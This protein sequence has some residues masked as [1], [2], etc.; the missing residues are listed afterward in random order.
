[1]NFHTVR[2]NIYVIFLW[3]F[4]WPDQS[5]L[6]L[7]SVQHWY[8]ASLSRPLMDGLWEYLIRSPASTRIVLFPQTNP[9]ARPA[10]NNEKNTSLTHLLSTMSKLNRFYISF[11][12]QFCHIIFKISAYKEKYIFNTKKILNCLQIRLQRFQPR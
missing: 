2:V 1:M 4:Y 10:T 11:Q 5:Q 3:L 9:T 6:L 8:T 12:Y 7:Y